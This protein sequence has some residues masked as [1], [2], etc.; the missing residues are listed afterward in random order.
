MKQRLPERRRDE[1]ARRHDDG[2]GSSRSSAAGERE[3]RAGSGDRAGGAQAAASAFQCGAA[4]AGGTLAGRDG[5][6][7]TSEVGENLWACESGSACGR[8]RSWESEGDSRLEASSYVVG[9]GDEVDFGRGARRLGLELNRA[10]RVLVQKRM[11]R[12]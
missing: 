3:R 6:K 8:R 11:R 1:G 5:G 12:D 2:R 4:V 9:D 10:P 7:T